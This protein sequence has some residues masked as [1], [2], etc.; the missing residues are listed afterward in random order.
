M[1]ERFKA[2][3]KAEELYKRSKRLKLPDFLKNQLLRAS[4]SVALNLAEGYGKKTDP[5]RRRYFTNALGSL[6]EC[7]AVLRME[8]QNDPEL[9]D[10]VDQ[11]GAMIYT[12]SRKYVP[13]LFL[14]LNLTLFPLLVLVLILLLAV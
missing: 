13:R 3:Q 7:E 1:L 4:S 8:D 9:R 6:R 11:L 12:M 2:F 14:R 5:D 10:C